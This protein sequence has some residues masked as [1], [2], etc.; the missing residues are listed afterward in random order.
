MHAARH[1]AY[2]TIA[3]HA[4]LIAYTIIALFP[5]F[6]ILINSFKSRAAIFREPLSLPNRGCCTTAEAVGLDWERSHCLGR[7]V[8]RHGSSDN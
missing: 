6:V 7:W 8:L 1:S 4:I 2:R 3:A 5:V